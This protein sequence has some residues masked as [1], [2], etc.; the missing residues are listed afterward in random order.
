MLQSCGSPGVGWRTDLKPGSGEGDCDDNNPN[1]WISLS[2]YKDLDGDGYTVGN[3]ETFCTGGS[4][5]AGYIAISSGQDCDDSDNTV[6]RS[7]QLYVD[8]DGDGYTVGNPATYCLG[9]NNPIGYSETS[10]GEDCD[11]SDATIWQLLQGYVDNDGDGYTVGGKVSVCSGASLP[12]GYV[13]TS[14]GSD[15]DDTNPNKTTDCIG[16]NG[17]CGTP[18]SLNV[19]VSGSQVTFSWSGTQFADIHAIMLKNVESGNYSYTYSS[20]ENQATRVVLKPGTYTWKVKAL[21]DTESLVTGNAS[22]WISGG[23]FTVP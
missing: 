2:G 4:L 14:L 18:K 22:D 9:G 12:A 23:T 7:V 6:W 8:A 20:K 15:C 21:C 5:P 16:A 10:L 11:D 19:S 1:V 13:A 17:P 3:R